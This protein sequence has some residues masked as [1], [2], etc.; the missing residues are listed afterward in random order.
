MMKKRGRWAVAA[1][2]LGAVATGEILM[3]APDARAFCGFYVSGADAKLTN[4]AT[5][6]VLLRDGLRT[7]LSMQNGYQGPPQ[8]FALVVPVPVVLKK[9]NVKTL[10]KDVFDHIDKLTAPRLVEYWEQDPCPKPVPHVMYDM[11]PAPM[12]MGAGA[13]AG[14]P[15]PPP[16][17]R[18]EAQFSVGEYDVVVL[19][20]TDSTAL[21]A[22]LKENHYKIPD[23]AEPYLRPYVQMGMKFFVAK[24]NVAKVRFER[25]GNGAVPSS[26][27]APPPPQ[28]IL[29]PLRFFYDS[30]SFNLPIRLG[31]IN[32]SGTQD[33][34][35]TILARNQRYEASNYDNIAIPTNINVSDATRKEFGSFYAKLFDQTMEKHPRSVVTEY[36]WQA[37]SCDPCPTPPLDGNDLATLGVDVLPEF[38]PPPPE[39]GGAAIVAPQPQIPW[40][41]ASSF[42]V[43]R[44][45][46]RY[47]KD[48]LGDDLFFRTAVPIVGGREFMQNDGTSPA[49]PGRGQ[50]L[51]PKLEEGARPDSSNN[52]QARYIIRHPWTGPIACKNP[53]RGIWG[54]PPNGNQ[55]PIEPASRIGF[56]PRGG[57]VTLN[58]FVRGALPPESILSRGGATPLLAIPPSAPDTAST[59]APVPEAGLVVDA[60]TAGGPPDAAPPGPPPTPPPEGGCAGCATTGGNAGGVSAIA[61]LL[62][63][64]VARMRRRRS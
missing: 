42:V 39:G 24:V 8:D 7:V 14:A 23:G 11:I 52:F 64:A 51:G 31:L 30:D 58:T 46:A 12:A 16:K 5:Q 9:E 28:A 62:G 48:S 26:G 19:S 15:A 35:V 43:T 50:Q 59:G 55:A 61:A 22:W 49:S 34:V 57:A 60:A 27:G 3:G 54:G 21:D 40:G 38:A 53:Q 44:L 1:A 33:L 10:N 37:G 17:V 32:S 63:L 47:S 25:V 45:H 29:S 2:V 13:P 18:I 20:A 6:V 56:L 4:N 36:S 41:L